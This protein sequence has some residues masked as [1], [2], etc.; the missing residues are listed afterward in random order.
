MGEKIISMRATLLVCGLMLAVASGMDHEPRVVG[1]GRLR[2]AGRLGR[3]PEE[4]WLWLLLHPRGAGQSGLCLQRQGLQH[5]QTTKVW[6]G[7]VLRRE[8]RLVPMRSQ[9]S[10][11]E[12]Q[13]WRGSEAP[14]CR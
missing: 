2:D 5:R 14:M 11:I 8:G 1:F 13:V 3:V 4:R 9:P 12:R 6:R 7:V 10:C